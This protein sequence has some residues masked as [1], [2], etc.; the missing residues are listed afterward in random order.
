MEAETGNTIA[1]M[2]PQLLKVM[3]FYPRPT[4]NEQ[5]SP[6]QPK[7]RSGMN[8][9]HRAEKKFSAERSQIMLASPTT[10]M[11]RYQR[12]NTPGQEPGKEATGHTTSRQ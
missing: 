11:N 2:V 10:S 7:R 8:N 9:Q 6:P 1:Q 3:Q 5:N 4:M 12:A